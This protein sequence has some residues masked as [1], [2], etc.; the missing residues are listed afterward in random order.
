LFFF[1]SCSF[2]LF[3]FL[4]N[5]FL[6][7]FLS[8]SSLFFFRFFPSSSVLFFLLFCFSFRFFSSLWL[9][10]YFKWQDPP[11]KF[12]PPPCLKTS[13]KPTPFEFAVPNKYLWSVSQIG[14][15]IKLV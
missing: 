13:S 11:H 15:R 10:C 14:T 7:F 1:S 5:L 3:F 6:L 9:C 8:S 4:S 2:L 12:I